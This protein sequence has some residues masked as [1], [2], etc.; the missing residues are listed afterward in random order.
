M[1]M[2]RKHP[3]ARDDI[4]YAQRQLN[5]MR[6]VELHGFND[7]SQTEAPWSHTEYPKLRAKRKNVKPATSVHSLS[8]S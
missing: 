3:E 8:Q 7:R 1:S 5:D 6:Q 2:P 4:L